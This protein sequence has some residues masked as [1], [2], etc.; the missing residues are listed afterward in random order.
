MVCAG[1]CSPPSR[2]EPYFVAD[3]TQICNPANGP[4]PNLPSPGPAYECPTW[5]LNRCRSLLPWPHASL[6]NNDMAA[7]ACNYLPRI[8][9]H[10]QNSGIDACVRTGALDRDQRF[11]TC[12]AAARCG[13]AWAAWP[14]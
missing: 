6:D 4:V 14:S 12:H 11:C 5:K 7:L 1:G 8:M 13:W 2:I 10:H 9:H 3:T